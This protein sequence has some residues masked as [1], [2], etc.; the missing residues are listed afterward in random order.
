MHKGKDQSHNGS[1]LHIPPTKISSPNYSRTAIQKNLFLNEKH[2]GIFW[3]EKQ[4]Q[5]SGP[6]GEEE[7]NDKTER[8]TGLGSKKTEERKRKSKDSPA[9]IPD[10]RRT[11]HIPGL[12]SR[13]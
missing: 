12:P 2:W 1:M 9:E 4:S 7:E 6:L 13:E 3:R 8:A 5:Q 10:R 11:S